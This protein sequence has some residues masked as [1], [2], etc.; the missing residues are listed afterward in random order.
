MEHRA[1]PNG[2][3][4]IVQIDGKQEKEKKK[5]KQHK[6]RRD[7]R[8]WSKLRQKVASIFI[9]MSTRFVI[10]VSV[11]WKLCFEHNNNNNRKKNQRTIDWIKSVFVNMKTRER[12][13]SH[14]HTFNTFSFYDGRAL[15]L[16]QSWRWRENS[17]AAAKS[18]HRSTERPK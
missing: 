13:R 6:G 5:K 9:G 2:Q 17:L 14:T 11:V 10:L 1:S 8:M 16:L 4:S 15:L 3:T 12:E 18:T 7:R